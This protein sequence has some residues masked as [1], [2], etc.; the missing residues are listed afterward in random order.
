MARRVRRRGFGL[1]ILVLLLAGVSGLVVLALLGPGRVFFGVSGHALDG[2]SW[3]LVE[4]DSHAPVPGTTV[5][6]EFRAGRVS[7]RTGC[8]QFEGDYAANLRRVQMG[9]IYRNLMSCVGQERQEQENR[10]MEILGT[11]LHRSPAF[12]RRVETRLE[13]LD[14]QG[15]PLLVYEGK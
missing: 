11:L 6:L 13:I 5:T 4:I 3:M 2:T 9:V 14:W 12:Y 7:G 15:I 10:Y 8:N 1:A